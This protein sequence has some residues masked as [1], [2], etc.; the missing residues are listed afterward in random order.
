MTLPAVANVNKSLINVLLIQAIHLRMELISWNRVRTQLMPLPTFFLVCLAFLRENVSLSERW[1]SSSSFS[2]SLSEETKLTRIFS[3]IPVKLFP[4]PEDCP[5]HLSYITCRTFYYR[6]NFLGEGG[7]GIILLEL[8]CNISEVL[9]IGKQCYCY[10]LL[11]KLIHPFVSDTRDVGL[12]TARKVK[13]KT[14]HVEQRIS[15]APPE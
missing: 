9:Q 1:A 6:G 15:L 7:G 4:H 2:F 5:P 10:G 14:T 12:H 13:V 3:G 8:S 11:W